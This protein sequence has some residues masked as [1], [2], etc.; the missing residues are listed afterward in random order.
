MG[1]SWMYVFRRAAGGNFAVKLRRIAPH[2]K[3][4]IHER[5]VEVVRPEAARAVVRIV[6]IIIPARTGKWRAGVSYNV[7]YAEIL[8][9]RIPSVPVPH[10]SAGVAVVGLGKYRIAH[11][12]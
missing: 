6:G 7:V 3:P 4:S 2:R 8:V 12:G 10:E 1:L 5:L 11:Y 9:N